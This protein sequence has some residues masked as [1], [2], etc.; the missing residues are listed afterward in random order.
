M[1]CAAFV[2]TS[3]LAGW[4]TPF[5]EQRLDTWRAALEVNLTAPFAMT[6]AAAPLL[7]ASGHGAVVNVASTYGVVGPV[8][9]LYE[10]TAMANPAAGSDRRP[11]G[12]LRLGRRREAAREPRRDGGMEGGERRML[13]MPRGHGR[14]IRPAIP[15]RMNAMAEGEAD[16]RA[17]ARSLPRARLAGCDDGSRRVRPA[18]GFGKPSSPRTGNGGRGLASNVR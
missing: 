10:G 11:R 1:H 5:A 2:G 4:A 8:W 17:H 12:D 14:I 6:Q 3:K 18:C 9:S 7:K 13:G 16:L 15:G